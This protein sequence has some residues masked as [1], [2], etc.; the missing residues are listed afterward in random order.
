MRR[1]SGVRE[2]SVRCGA[3]YEVSGDRDGV[4]GGMY[5]VYKGETRLLASRYQ[6]EKV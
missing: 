2:G 5:E 4:S 1:S 6:V 3:G